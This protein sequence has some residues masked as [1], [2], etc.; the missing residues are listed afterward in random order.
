[1][2]NRLMPPKKQRMQTTLAHPATAFPEAIAQTAQMMPTSPIAL[3]KRPAFERSSRGFV[4]R[5]VTPVTARFII[6]E[7]G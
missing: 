2:A 1:M 5:L 6:F 4:D 3:K 7:R